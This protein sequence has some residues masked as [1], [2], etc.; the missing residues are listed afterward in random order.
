MVGTTDLYFTKAFSD[1]LVRC[2][3]RY[4][5]PC[6]GCFAVFA[7]IAV[8]LAI[9]I[10]ALWLLLLI[11][12]IAYAA[13]I[14]P[15]TAQYR[16]EWWKNFL[17]YAFFTPIMAFF[18][19]LTA[20]ISN[21]FKE[22]TILQSVSDPALY[23]ELGNSDLATFVFRVASNLLLLVFLIAALKVADMAGIYGAKGITSIAQK[24]IFLPF[25]LLGWE[26]KR[27]VGLLFVKYITNKEWLWKTEATAEQ[28]VN[29]RKSDILETEK[30]VAFN[31][32]KLNDLK[33]N[34]DLS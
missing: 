28:A 23:K 31:K 13:G 21:Q 20:L 12:P 4:S 2:Y 19:N 30:A 10:V 16:G 26:Q 9:R 5:W 7:A 25:A 18:L 8:F 3:S 24:G 33:Q 1:D 14:L 11:S 22:N 32:S 34:L 29:K 6:L 17:R 27:P 15:S